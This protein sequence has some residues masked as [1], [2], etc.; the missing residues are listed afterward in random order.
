MGNCPTISHTCQPHL[1]MQKINS[2]IYQCKL[3]EL[4]SKG[5]PRF[6]CVIP[7]V[8]SFSYDP[9]RDI[10]NIGQ[11]HIQNS[12]KY[13]VKGLQWSFPAKLANNFNTLTISAKTFTVDVRLGS[14]C[15]SNWRYCKC[16]VQVDC[17]SMEHVIVDQCIK[18]TAPT[19]HPLTLKAPPQEKVNKIMIPFSPSQ[20]FHTK[21]SISK[22]QAKRYSVLTST[23][24]G[25]PLSESSTKI[26]NF[27]APT[28]SEHKLCKTGNENWL[29]TGIKLGCCRSSIGSVK[30]YIMYVQ[31][32]TVRVRVRFMIRINL[33]IQISA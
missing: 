28:A 8:E 31:L 18:P 21:F 11:G 7:V 3:R 4:G 27:H 20:V 26:S 22:S 17:K 19:F 16:E 13:L 23:K 29:P 1:P 30:H 14:K 33:G 6:P 12:V 2:P 25:P 15:A 32:L 5:S 24:L 9:F 10:I